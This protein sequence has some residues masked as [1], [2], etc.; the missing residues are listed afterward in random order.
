MSSEANRRFLQM[1]LASGLE[2]GAVTPSDAIRHVTPDV[3]A[4][5]LPTEVMAK[6]VEASLVA[7]S[8]TANL[9][10]DTLG[11]EAMA[12]YC[13]AETLW[14]C[15]RE[16]AERFLAEGSGEVNAVAVAKSKASDPG[17][18][19][20][21]SAD[22][23]SPTAPHATG[24]AESASGERSVANADRQRA[25]MAGPPVIPPIKPNVRADHRAKT[26]PEEGYSSTRQA[27]NARRGEFGE[28]TD[29][30]GAWTQDQ[31]APAENDFEIVEETEEAEA[32]AWQKDE[33][34]AKRSAV[35]P[36]LAP[37]PSVS[38]KPR[39]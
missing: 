6:L 39:S 25:D 29:V 10:I 1:V 7:G 5:S 21:Q 30:A 32:A 12:E 22:K 13:P 31:E 20:K 33:V 3:L 23:Q 34:T 18:P 16:Q 15:V 28:D 26:L 4:E 24:V 2:C 27:R 35:P 38:R 36:A 19:S 9:I 11:T 14:D 17:E 8:M 37:P